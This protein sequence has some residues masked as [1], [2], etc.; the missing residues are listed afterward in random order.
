[1][2]DPETGR[3]QCLSLEPL[4][5]LNQ[6][7]ACALRQA[8]AA[9]INGVADQGVSDVRHVDA[10]LMRASGFELNLD[11]RV[12][13]EP[14]V[15]AV[16]RDGF[17][18]IVSYGKALAITAVTS[19]GKIHGAAARQ[20]TLDQ[21]KVF[22]VDGM[23]LKLLDQK[24]VRLD[25]F[26][27]HQKTAGVLVDPVNDARSGNTIQF[28]RMVQEG[29]LERAV[30]MARG[31]VNHEALWFFDDD[32]GFVFVDDLQRNCFW[33]DIRHHL[34]AWRQRDGLSAED[35]SARFGGLTAQLHGAVP[36]P[37]LD[38]IS[39]IV[40]KQKA[41]GLVQALSGQFE[42]DDG[43]Q[44]GFGIHFSPLVQ[45]RYTARLGPIPGT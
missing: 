29:I 7:R 10:D 11:Q 24:L 12:G 32:D 26:R 6:G 31:R 44:V 25:G 16:M 28:R 21:C 42:R 3:V 33:G 2:V 9:T 39:R 20:G 41:Q 45:S 35:F 36:D 37:V 34:E 40:G 43:S 18:A 30:V 22:T 1:M 15:N 23:C 14:L 13:G 8:G 38:T 4:K 17:L 19:D 27:D 5:G